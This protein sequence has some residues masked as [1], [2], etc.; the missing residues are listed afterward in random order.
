MQIRDE[1]CAVTP[2]PWIMLHVVVSRFQHDAPGL[3][4]ILYQ[5]CD[6]S[7]VRVE[8][9]LTAERA[10]PTRGGCGSSATAVEKIF[11]SDRSASAFA[12]SGLSFRRGV[13]QACGP[14]RGV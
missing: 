8:R 7:R 2:H 14:R 1:Q 4:V 12:D 10:P 6:I 5:A 9:I 11:A 13:L 3:K